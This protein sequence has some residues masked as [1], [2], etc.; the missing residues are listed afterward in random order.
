M[1]LMGDDITARPDTRLEEEDEL[2]IFLGAA[3]P[4]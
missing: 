2:A 1:A 3:H 4:P